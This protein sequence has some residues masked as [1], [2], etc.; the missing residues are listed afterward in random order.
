[1]DVREGETNNREVQQF[2]P[3]QR[4]HMQSA[5]SIVSILTETSI[6]I[7]DWETIYRATRAEVVMISD[8]KCVDIAHTSKYT[9][10]YN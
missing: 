5:I 8:R 4:K 9:P 1:M 2:Q 7:L 10:R 6:N 3:L